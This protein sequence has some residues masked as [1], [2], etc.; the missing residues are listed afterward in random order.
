M[1]MSREAT[2]NLKHIYHSL[3]KRDLHAYH[4][5]SAVDH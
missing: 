2:H 1:V 3:G 4:D 5:L